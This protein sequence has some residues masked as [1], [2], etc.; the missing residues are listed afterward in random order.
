[1][2]YYMCVCLFIYLVYAGKYK[3]EEVGKCQDIA[4]I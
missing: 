2:L 3:W 4:D 1:M